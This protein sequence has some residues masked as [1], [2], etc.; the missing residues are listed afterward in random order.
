[1]KIAIITEAF[2]PSIGGMEVSFLELGRVLVTEGHE[3]EVFTLK[4]NAENKSEDSIDGIRI[5]RITNA[6]TYFSSIWGIRNYP[7]VIRFSIDLARKVKFL[8]QFDFIVFNIWPV[9]PSIFLPCFLKPT[10]MTYWCEVYDKLFWRFIYKLIISFGPRLHCGVNQNICDFLCSN[11]TISGNQVQAL[12]SGV[13]SS[14]YAC[15]SNIKQNCSILF[16]GRLAQHKDPEAVIKAFLHRELNTHGYELNIVG[17]GPLYQYL[18]D[19]YR[20]HHSIFIH[21]SVDEATKIQFLKQASLLVLPSKREGFPRVC[22]EAA[23]AGTPILTVL[24]PSNGT[25]NVVSQYGIGWIS[26]ANLDEFSEK[27]ERYGNMKYWEWAT[28]SKHCKEVAQKIFDWNVVTHKFL[29]I[30]GAKNQ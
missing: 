1:M 30:A 19:K 27:I 26:N 3:V 5:H 16:F 11:Y 6:F 23:A 22:A 12:I 25:V 14:L 10:T 13:H 7:D 18:N 9:I 28:V 20:N 8:N 24:Y 4:L 21:G 2:F 29:E 15:Q 17:D